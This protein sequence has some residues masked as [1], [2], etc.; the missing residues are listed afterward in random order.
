MRRAPSEPPLSASREPRAARGQTAMTTDIRLE[1]LT[2]RDLLKLS[3]AA[4]T[5]GAAATVL[6]GCSPP[7][8]RSEYPYA[9]TNLSDLEF[10]VLS[11]AADVILPGADSGLPDHRSLPVLRNAD[12]M[13]AIAPEPGRKGF[14]QS[15]VLFE[16]A[17]LV[18][19]FKPFTRLDPQQAR[20][21]LV[22]WRT[23]HAIQKAIYS[24]VTR[25]IIACYWAEEPT[26]KVVKYQGPV[27]LRVQIA[28]LGNAPL[29]Q[30][31]T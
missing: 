24:S 3:L 11:K 25:L 8:K 19:R 17:A 21:Y 4:G 14:G 22:A 1:G 28:S 16:Y 9:I 10:S 13:L 29:P 23:G 31:Q 27:H 26:W 7:L 5:L 30:D 20:D 18:S 6:P 15:L 2:R 12:H